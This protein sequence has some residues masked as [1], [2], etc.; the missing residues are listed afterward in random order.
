MD[1]NSSRERLTIPEY[2]RN[3][4][5]LIKHAKG[6]EDPEERQAFTERIV[7]LMMQMH[8][9]NK[10]MEDYRVK[11]WSHVFRIAEYE[12]DVQPPDEVDINI[13]YENLKPERVPYPQKD[14][15]YR[16]YGQ[17]IQVL[18]DK[19]KEM[20]PGPVQ[21]GFV[22]V[23]GSYMKLAY[24]TWNKEPYVSDE[25][26]LADLDNLSDGELSLSHEGSL[27]NLA[28]SNNRKRKRNTNQNGKH[29]NKS[30]NN[31]NQNNNARRNKRFKRK[32]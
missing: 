27:D 24:R 13:R 8:P 9:Q 23:I 4:Q 14:T 2:G 29:S 5:N 12:L 19:A 6:I 11:I 28:Q 21:D 15:K 20:E 26:I 22:E 18:I 7:D 30:N 31:S 32:G 17:N 16:H 10:N 3:V 25:T 1:Y